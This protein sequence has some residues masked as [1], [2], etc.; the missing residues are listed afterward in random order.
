MPSRYRIGELSSHFEVPVETIRYYERKGLL[1]RP[2]RSGGNYRL[3]TQADHDRLEFI[4][5]C[6]ALD[7]TL[8]E[9]HSLLELRDAP[10][11]GCAEV[12]ALLDEHIQHVANRLKALKTLQSQLQTLRA[13]CDSPSITRDCGIL[14][15]LAASSAR[16]ARAGKLG[17][18]G[19]SRGE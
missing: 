9:I 18:H 12:N 11:Q 17:V 14:S 16:P 8:Q 15:G 19:P 2:D 13:C 1:P 7:L 4:L 3:Y 10:E 5:N 6:R